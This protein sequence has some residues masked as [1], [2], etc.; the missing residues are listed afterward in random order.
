MIFTQ[1]VK[2][3]KKLNDI[4]K[5]ILKDREKRLIIVEFN[6]RKDTK[7]Y[8]FHKCLSFLVDDTDNAQ[9]PGYPACGVEYF[10]SFE[11][12]KKKIKALYKK[13][14]YTPR[15]PIDKYVCK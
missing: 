5:H 6:K 4:T 13:V 8:N 15:Y 11:K 7:Y 10:D 12:G 9:C 3:I 14:E 2:K 1:E